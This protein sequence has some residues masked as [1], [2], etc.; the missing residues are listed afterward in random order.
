[1]TPEEYRDAVETY[2]TVTG[3]SAAVG[4]TLRSHH[5]TIVGKWKAT[6]RE[7]G[8]VA[9]RLVES[10]EIPN[11]PREHLAAIGTELDKLR[12]ERAARMR[13]ERTAHTCT[14]C[15]GIGLVVVPHPC[16]VYQGRI[17]GFYDARSRIRRRE[18]VTCAVIC[19]AAKCW[20]GERALQASRQGEKPPLLTMD[21]YLRRVGVHVEPT[22]LLREWQLDQAKRSRAAEEKAAT[23][24]DDKDELERSRDVF[25]S[26]TAN[27]L[28]RREAW[29]ES[30]Y[31]DDAEVDDEVPIPA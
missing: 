23:T 21:S 5:R 19:T 4:E 10:K 16:C 11:W 31:R 30:P 20:A 9:F 27:I 25:R 22:V 17:I 18:V 7:L 8:E 15:E 13:P 26:I 14:V 29:A 3:G 6:G 12:A 2:C 28:A 1:M 24:K